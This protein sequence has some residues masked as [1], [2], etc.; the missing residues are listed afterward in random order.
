MQDPCFE[1]E[2]GTVIGVVIPV[3]FEEAQGIELTKISC[4]Q[5][6][7]VYHWSGTQFHLE[8]I[9]LF[10]WFYLHRIKQASRQDWG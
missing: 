1:G 4:Q 5:S 7:I 2:T 9:H 10:D 3:R 8:H 6:P